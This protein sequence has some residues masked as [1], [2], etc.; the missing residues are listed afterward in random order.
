MRLD[1]QTSI[2]FKLD[3]T[4]DDKTT[5]KALDKIIDLVKETKQNKR[6][7]LGNLYVSNEEGNWTRI[8]ILEEIKKKIKE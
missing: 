1:K 2:D 5:L 4:I 8:N 3:G 7:D 6:D